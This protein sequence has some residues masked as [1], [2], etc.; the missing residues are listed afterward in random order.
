MTLI[1]SPLA[2]VV[3]TGLA[4]AVSA[5]RSAYGYQSQQG[6]EKNSDEK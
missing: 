4:P 2:D 3:V 1:G 6:Q 5:S